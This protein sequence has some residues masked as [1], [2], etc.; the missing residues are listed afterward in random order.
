MIEKL[1]AFLNK[2]S[3]WS[4]FL[5]RDIERIEKENLTIVTKTKIDQIKFEL[6]DMIGRADKLIEEMDKEIKEN[7]RQLGLL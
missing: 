4:R 3:N 5:Q 1:E 2:F 7:E 6:F